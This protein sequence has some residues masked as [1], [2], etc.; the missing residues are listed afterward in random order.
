MRTS[1]PRLLAAGLCGALAAHLVAPP[2]ATADGQQNLRLDQPGLEA[3]GAPDAWDQNQGGGITIA[4]LDTGVD[5]SHPDL[6]DQVTVTD[7][8]TGQDRG[9]GDDGYG[10]HGTGLA[11]IVAASGHG[12]EHVGGVM[13]VAPESDILSVRVADDAGSGAGNSGVADDAL[14]RGIDHAAAEGARVILLPESAQDGEAERSAVRSAVHN[15]ALVVAPASS[16]LAG[17]EDV[18]GAGAVDTDLVPAGSSSENVALYAPGSEVAALAPDR[19]YTK[20]DGAAPAAAFVAGAAA[21]VRADNPQLLPD[22]VASA[23]VDGAQP[24]ATESE[25][26]VLHVPGAA[27]T[28]GDTAEDVPLYDESLAADD[29]PLIPVWAWWAGGALLLMVAVGVVIWLAR[30]RS[31]PYGVTEPENTAD[32]TPSGAQPGE[33]GPGRGRR[34]KGGRRRTGRAASRG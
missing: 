27:A 5:D 26:G 31:D 11:G 4:V 15:G 8:F 24:A 6:A 1:A 10:E 28:A 7:D 32:T 33:P 22:Q 20:L 21:L 17:H 18:L 13:G 25:A 19:D 23:L 30:P 16:P 3:V 34:R 12:Q 2:S 9:P 14:Q 29:D